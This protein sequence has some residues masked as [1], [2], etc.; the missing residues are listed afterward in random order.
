MI[1]PQLY[2][3]DIANSLV[4]QGCLEPDNKNVNMKIERG[5]GIMHLN[6]H[7]ST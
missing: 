5:Q 1:F 4:G 2:I 6:A 3:L 7:I